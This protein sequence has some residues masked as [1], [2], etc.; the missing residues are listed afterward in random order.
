MTSAPGGAKVVLK[1]GEELVQQGRYVAVASVPFPASLIASAPLIAQKLTEKGFS[2][3]QVSTEK[4][5]GFPLASEGDYYLSVTWKNA[6]QAFAV[7]SAVV[8]HRKVA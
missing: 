4:P 6:P 1:P 7:P 8:E 2:N 5:A 3:V